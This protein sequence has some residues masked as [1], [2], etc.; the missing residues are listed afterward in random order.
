MH[1]GLRVH[2]LG[3]SSNRLRS[4]ITETLRPDAGTWVSGVNGAIAE[5]C[6]CSGESVEIEADDRLI[7]ARI[8]GG[9]ISVSLENHVAALGFNSDGLPR[10][11]IVVLAVPR[12]I[13]RLF[14][15]DGLTSLGRDYEAINPDE[16][17]A[18]LYD[19]GLGRA[20]GA[21]GVRTASATL[22][23]SLE[24]SLGLQ[25]QQLLSLKGA[26]ILAESPV[27]VVR[28][29]V[30]RIEVYNAIPKPGSV[31]PKGP[32]THFLPSL[33]SAGGDLPSTM[34]IPSAYVPCAIY[35]PMAHADSR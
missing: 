13:T 24:A 5:F 20:A 32:H 33:I 15:N 23:A 25:W 28:N 19:F 11:D 31:S 8:Q 21:F 7:A 22:R 17:E 12:V 9:A 27:R 10:Q 26:E 18:T 34:Q 3:W 16:R 30:G 1:L 14:P 2:H 4:F 29:P 35:Y 6:V